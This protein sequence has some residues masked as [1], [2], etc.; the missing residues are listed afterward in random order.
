[1]PVAGNNLAELL[2]LTD[3]VSNALPRLEGLGSTAD[4]I[5]SSLL[6]LGFAIELFP[7]GPE[8]GAANEE[9][10]IRYDDT[11]ENLATTA[12]FDDATNSILGGL[13]SFANFDGVLDYDTDIATHFVFG[14]D[15]EGFYLS[16]ASSIQVETTASGE[17]G[18][19]FTLPLPGLSID[20]TGTATVHLVATLGFGE[21]QDR[22][23]SGQLSGGALS[24]LATDVDG[25]ATVSLNMTLTSGS[26]AGPSP[27]GSPGAGSPDS[28][29]TFSGLWTMS[30]VDEAVQ[31]VSQ[32]VTTPSVN[33][34]VHALLPA[35]SMG[36][37]PFLSP[38]LGGAL[39]S[40]LDGVQ[41]PLIADDLE[42]TLDL[43]NA[44]LGLDIGAAGEIDD[45]QQWSA[46]GVEVVY[47]V[48]VATFADWLVNGLPADTSDIIRLRVNLDELPLEAIETVQASLGTFLFDTVGV[49]VGI[50]NAALGG[51]M[52]FGLDTSESGV[53]LLTDDGSG[54]RRRASRP[55]STWSPI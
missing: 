41:V 28:G 19:S 18:D 35:L 13:S 40:L 34:F 49:S 15:V 55:I 23:R 10:R 29:A 9:L 51:Q 36:V 33:D 38:E 26:A 20:A 5:R 6:E 52:T 37:E 14:V 43:A 25:E 3:V 17:I 21:P 54:C 42:R 7:G 22:I 4:Q 30:I 45:Y 32:A 24:A 44:L 8:G 53:Y 46:A 48:D 27:A 12:Q 1:M 11:V 16:G 50:E 47:L 2:G 39:D 31:L